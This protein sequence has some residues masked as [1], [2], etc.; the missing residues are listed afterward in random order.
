[1]QQRDNIRIETGKKLND[2]VDQDMEFDQD[3]D[4]ELA[5][6][7]SALEQIDSIMQAEKKR[8]IESN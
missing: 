6:V 2:S 3:T 4:K 1:M 8:R 7:Q 5:D